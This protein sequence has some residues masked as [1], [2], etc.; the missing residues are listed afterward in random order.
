MGRKCKSLNPLE[1]VIEIDVVK[2]LIKAYPVFFSFF[3]FESRCIE[4]LA[5]MDHIEGS[6]VTSCK[7][8]QKAVKVLTNNNCIWKKKAHGLFYNPYLKTK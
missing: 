4:T 8:S 3:F 6:D 1:L 5:E 7:S 2:L